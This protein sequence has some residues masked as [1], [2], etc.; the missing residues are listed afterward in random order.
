M[1]VSTYQEPPAASRTRPR[2]DSSCRIDWVLRA[3]RRARSSGSPSAASN[4][5]TVIASAPP[6]AAAKQATVV[7]SMFTHGS[8][9][10]IIAAE[11]TACCRCPRA[12]SRRAERGDPGPDPPGRAQLGDRGELVRGDREPELHRVQRRV[13]VEPGVG[14]RPQ[15]RHPDRGGD[16]QLGRVARAGVVVDG[17]VDGRHPQVRVVRARAPAGSRSAAA[18][19]RARSPIGSA[20]RLP[21]TSAGSRPRSP[22]SRRYAAAAS[23]VCAP[24]SSATGARST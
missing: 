24:A 22:T 15:V 1:S 18:P 11:V 14:Q 13:D 20:P 17:R 16:R 4:G 9:R 21:R 2:L 3:I 5:S 12:G 19:V 23:A 7:R 10:V 8:R 6:T